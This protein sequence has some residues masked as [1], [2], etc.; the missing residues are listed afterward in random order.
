ME[1]IE[2]WDDELDFDGPAFAGSSHQPSISSRLSIRSDSNAGEDEWNVPLTPNDETSTSQ[3]ILSAKLVGIPIPANVPASALLGGTIKRLGKKTSRQKMKNDDW[4]DDMDF[5]DL[6][7]GTLTLKPKPALASFAAEE[8]DEFSDWAEGS[9]GIRDAGARRDTT[10]STASHVMSPSFASTAHDSEDDGMDGLVFPVGNLSLELKKRN[11]NDDTFKRLDAPVTR[12]APITP[13]DDHNFDEDFLD[14]GGGNTSLDLRARTLNRNVKPSWKPPPAR[15]APAKSQTTLTFSAGGAGTRIPRPVP[16]RTSR[17]DTVMESTTP[18]VHK[19][20]R[21]E[22]LSTAVHPAAPLTTASHTSGPSLLRSKRSMPALRSQPSATLRPP[23][24][25]TNKLHSDLQN[26]RA[27]QHVNRRES[28]GQGRAQSP[29]LRTHSRLSHGHTF[30]PETPTR[31]ARRD[32]APPSLTREAIAK[33][34]ITKPAR[35]KNFGD[36]TELDTFD[37]LPT[38]AVRE[39]KFMKVP[40]MRGPPKVLRSQP[41][42]SKLRE[43]MTTPLPPSLP[44]SPTKS[45]SSLPS[46]ARDTAA[47]RNAREQKLNTIKPSREAVQPRTNWAA[48]VAARTP[49]SSPTAKRAG[50]R[51]PTLITPMGKDNIRHCKFNHAIILIRICLTIS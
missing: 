11:D 18:V 5:G 2:N 28:G 27:G 34:N 8:D 26:A 37:D 1:N 17:L 10:G 21:P 9:L 38:S 3:A 51:G 19:L 16:S 30:V 24:M 29:I 4:N 33:R 49:H 47:S 40:S 36:G 13:I 25:P 20:Q 32:V 42:Q 50:R 46:W 41:S 7:D 31:L 23:P 35:R 15:D 12:P 6:D 44:R 43:K 39:S 22:P 14:F 48:Q 45:V